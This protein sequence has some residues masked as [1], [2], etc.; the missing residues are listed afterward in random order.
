MSLFHLRDMMFLY[1][2]RIAF[3]YYQSVEPK[4]VMYYSTWRN[5]ADVFIDMF[6][7]CTSKKRSACCPCFRPGLSR[8]PSQNRPPVQRSKRPST[9]RRLSAQPSQPSLVS[10]CPRALER[11]CVT[12]CMTVQRFRQLS[13]HKYSMNQINLQPVQMY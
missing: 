5:A 2:F 12:R 9:S 3:L 6:G 13:V 11:P 4:D 8:Q 1:M 7:V 10:R